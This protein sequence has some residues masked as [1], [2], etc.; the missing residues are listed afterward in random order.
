VQSAEY[1]LALLNPNTTI[2]D[3][4]AMV[5]TASDVMPG[6]VNVIGRTAERGA[7]I[8]ETLAEEV[9]GAAEVVRMVAAEPGFDSYLIGCFGDPGLAAAAETVRAP[10]LGIGAVALEMAA[11]LP[12]RFAVLT[13]VAEAIE[14]TDE[15]VERHGLARRCAGV[16]PAGEATSAGG[17]ADGSDFERLAEA[18][19]SARD[20]LG[21]DTL[22]LGCGSMTAARAQLAQELGVAVCD[23]VALGALTAY[24]LLRA[25]VTARAAGRA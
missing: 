19:R 18:G 25:G 21:A 6:G 4:R 7:A 20:E 13:T 24:A 5:A 3:T 8:I 22:V 1:T 2:T 12:G 9:V 23:G 14:G 11:K 17:W 10:V 16:V 15:L